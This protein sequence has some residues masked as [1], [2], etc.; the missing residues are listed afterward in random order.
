VPVGTL[1]AGWRLLTEGDRRGGVVETYLCSGTCAI[2]W[3]I[4]SG[5]WRHRT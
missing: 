3:I 1:P 2:E 5:E 4:D